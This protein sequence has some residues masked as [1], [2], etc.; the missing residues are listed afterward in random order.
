MIVSK[1][2]KATLVIAFILSFPVV[3]EKMPFNMFLHVWTHVSFYLLRIPDSH[4]DI[5][6]NEIER[7]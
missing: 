6:F 2:L 1:K 7:V 4:L 5:V 3:D